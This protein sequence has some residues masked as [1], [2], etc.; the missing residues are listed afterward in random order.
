MKTSSL[1]SRSF[2]SLVSWG[3]IFV[4]ASWCFAGWAQT[5][6]VPSF[7]G[8]PP[9]KTDAPY[10][11]NAKNDVSAKRPLSFRKDPLFNPLADKALRQEVARHWAVGQLDQLGHRQQTLRYYYRHP[12]S[13][14]I[15]S[16]VARDVQKFLAI[17]QEERASNIAIYGDDEEFKRQVV[18]KGLLA[19]DE[20]T[21]LKFGKAELTLIDDHYVVRY[22]HQASEMSFIILRPQKTPEITGEA[23]WPQG[24]S[25]AELQ[26]TWPKKYMAQHYGDPAELFGPEQ[27]IALTS[28]HLQQYLANQQVE[29]NGCKGRH[30]VLVLLPSE[31][32]A[33]MDWFVPGRVLPL[34]LPPKLSLS[35]WK[36]YAKATFFVPESGH[37]PLALIAASVQFAITYSM[38]MAKYYLQ[39][40]GVDFSAIEYMPAVNSAIFGFVVGGFFKSYKTWLHRG[41]SHTLKFMKNCL[42]KAIF[43]YIVVK[44]GFGDIGHELEEGALLLGSLMIANNWLSSNMAKTNLLEKTTRQRKTREN[45]HSLAS[46][47]AKHPWLNKVYHTPGLKQVVDK[48]KFLNLKTNDILYQWYYNYYFFLKMVDLSGLP[49]GTV[50]LWTSIPTLQTHNRKLFAKAYRDYLA[51]MEERAQQALPDGGTHP[52]YEYSRMRIM[53]NAKLDAA[54]VTF[55]RVKFTKY[56]WITLPVY[57]AYNMLKGAAAIMGKVA[58]VAQKLAE[59]HF[60]PDGA[61]TLRTWAAEYTRDA[62]I[63]RD[64]ASLMENWLNETLEESHGEGDLGFIDYLEK[65]A[66]PP[67][68][69]NMPEIDRVAVQALSPVE[70]SYLDAPAVQDAAAAADAS[71]TPAKLV[72]KINDLW[73][74]EITFVT[75]QAKNIMPRL[76]GEQ[77]DALAASTVQEMQ[78][79]LEG[80][81]MDVNPVELSLVSRSFLLNLPET[82]A[83]DGPAALEWAAQALVARKGGRDYP[84]DDS[85]QEESA[86]EE[87]AEH[88]DLGP[89]ERSSGSC[90]E[91]LL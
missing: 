75:Q 7:R 91:W 16:E 14:R 18:D 34:Y 30:A 13:A 57:A 46:E 36:N 51:K 26:D 19:R 20:K 29:S 71:T 23:L 79:L 44:F 53:E 22:V 1:F 74:E 47:L 24:K 33:A 84:D 77:V 25:A 43:T 39:N 63:L 69:L 67:A 80:S 8:G 17:A 81:K 35:R 6:V 61:K 41:D 72:N 45:V 11:Y 58:T 15:E 52:D 73:Q 78:T 88:D 27:K 83:M 87:A 82:V 28:R 76:S 37:L 59:R 3:A 56:L 40:Q 64:K 54:K 70:A 68:R 89:E 55:K 5:V 65:V 66:L 12:L 90:R 50:A 2:S 85:S 21:G 10:A 31:D 60:A 42:T 86:E 49:L 4:M 48:S 38:S 32:H 62:Q 9:I